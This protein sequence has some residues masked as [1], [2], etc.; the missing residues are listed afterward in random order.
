MHVFEWNA[1][2]G[3]QHLHDLVDATSTEFG[4]DVAVHDE[5]ALVGAPGASIDTGEV[6]VYRYLGGQ[7]FEWV[8]QGTLPAP[9]LGTGDRFGEALDLS[10]TRAVVGAPN[11]DTSNFTDVGQ[12]FTFELD[13]TGTNWSFGVALLNPQEGAGDL[14]GAAVSTWGN[15]VAIGAPNDE[16]VG[17]VRTGQVHVFEF[18][19]FTGSWNL[20]DT[21]SDPTNNAGTR[22][23]E[24]VAISSNELLVGAPFSA[25]FG[26]GAVYRFH[27]LLGTW[28]FLPIPAPAA[29]QQQDHFGSSLDLCED[30]AV[31]GAPDA[32]GTGTDSGSA[33]AFGIID[34]DVDPQFLGNTQS[35]SNSAGGTLELTL[36]AG[37]PF[38]GDTFLVMSNVTG[39]QPGFPYHPLRAPVLSG[40]FP[41]VAFVL[42]LNPDFWFNAFL[43]QPAIND[44]IGTF[45]QD[46][47]ATLTFDWAAGLNPF[48]VGARIHFCYV[49]ASDGL[50]EPSEVVWVDIV[51]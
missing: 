19:D 18:V 3:F 33:V 26:T 37:P 35:I 46:G 47:N 44:W 31:A 41:H 40:V 43:S 2:T 36:Q 12:A 9:A 14:F 15:Q 28:L 34:P 5:W 20:A 17:L 51:P 38:A 23:G 48:A 32:D 29:Y 6:Q 45:D 13:P 1:F 4:F 22:F 24:A 39:S 10:A 42:P 7:P 30:L 11:Y 16:N 27:R 21:T 49:N 25:P 50:F 8:S